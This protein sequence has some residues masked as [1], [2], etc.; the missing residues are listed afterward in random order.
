MNNKSTIQEFILVGL[1]SSPEYQLTIFWGF[2]FLYLA[3]LV[4]NFLFIL[5][6]GTCSKL[7]TPM[8]FLLVNLSITNM[9]CISVT[10]PKLLQ[11]TLAHRKTISF[12]GC[13]TQ[14][15]L[16]LWA[17]CTEIMLLS[18]MAFDR[19]SA[20]CRPLQYPVIM[21]K[22]VCVVMVT[23]V[24]V[25]GMVNSA[26]HTGLVLQLSFCDSNIINHFFCDLPPLLALSC[27][28]ISINETMAYAAAAV[29][30]MGSC[31]L[32]LISYMFILAAIFRIRS[33]EGKKKAF[34]T[35]SSHL[36]V[37]SFY[38]STIIYTYI[39]PASSYS[40]EEDKVVAIL[41]SVV[42]PVLNPLIY[43]LRNKDVKEALRN[44]RYRFLLR[45]T[46]EKWL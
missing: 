40:L 42:T 37:V 10:A 23:G 41:Y 13:V 21:K 1:S 39:K 12:S 14:V 30:T 11:T 3:A 43:S 35:C 8:Y 22:E 29:F 2:S 15:Y 25:T 28:D 5:T 20:I 45:L 27:S 9:I 36:L 38:F 19:Y 24:W 31:V 6:I 44:L 16:F 33:T 46:I 32:T 34:S 18:F 4:G 26:V 17:L 7:H